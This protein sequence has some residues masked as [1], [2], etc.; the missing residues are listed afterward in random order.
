MYHR[1]WW[2]DIEHSWS[3]IKLHDI[4]PKFILLFPIQ[5]PL[6]KS[7]SGSYGTLACGNL[8]VPLWGMGKFQVL[9]VSQIP[10]IALPMTAAHTISEKRKCEAWLMF[11]GC[12]QRLC[13]G[14][15][16]FSQNFLD[17]HYY[18]YLI[19][20]ALINV[21]SGNEVGTR[22]HGDP[23][24]SHTSPECHL[25]SRPTSYLAFMVKYS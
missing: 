16:F 7:A 25:T 24:H 19:N 6:E 10:L 23:S 14:L 13:T 5:S 12:T 15:L 3:L 21:E 4:P 9:S 18:Y 1:Q 20:F 2:K 22:T 8:P 17:H 11:L